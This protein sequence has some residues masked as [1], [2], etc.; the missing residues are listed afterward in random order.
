MEEESALTFQATFKK[1]MTGVDG[2]WVLSLDMSES[3][4]DMIADI[5]RL[6]GVLLQVA[7]IPIDL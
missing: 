4:G 5:A 6:K 2:G 7:I 3:S 1:A